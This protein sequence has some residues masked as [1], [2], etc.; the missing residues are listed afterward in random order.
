MISNIQLSYEETITESEWLD[1]G[2]KMAALNKLKHVTQLISYQDW[3]TDAD[4]VEMIYT[5]VGKNVSL[6]DW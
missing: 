1:S 3:M 5:K 6:Q 4:D 2:T